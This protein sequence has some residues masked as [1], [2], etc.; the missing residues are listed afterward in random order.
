LLQQAGVSGVLGSG[1]RLVPDV[2]SRPCSVHL[3]PSVYMF[4]GSVRFVGSRGHVR[5][6]HA[7]PDGN[8]DGVRFFCHSNFGH[9]LEIL[10]LD[11]G[12]K[13]L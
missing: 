5:Y 9:A 7:K 4:L 1:A 8:A 11:V 2:V 10:M 3:K 13:G 12:L 6:L